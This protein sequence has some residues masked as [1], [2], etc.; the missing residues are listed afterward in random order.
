M[1]ETKPERQS[2]ERLIPTGIPEID[3]EYGGLIRLQPHPHFS[4]VTIEL[5]SIIIPLTDCADTF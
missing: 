3:N 2:I 5:E 4:V 1:T